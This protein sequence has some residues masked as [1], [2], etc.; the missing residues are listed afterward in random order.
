MRSI[1][2][3]YIEE[4]NLIHLGAS[5]D[6]EADVVRLQRL[7]IKVTNMAEP[8]KKEPYGPPAKKEE[9]KAQ[10]DLFFTPFFAL[11]KDINALFEHSIDNFT[12]MPTIWGP[13]L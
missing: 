1:A 2:Y 13:G 5:L 12:H 10:S 8:E 6:M 11:Q 3:I 4:R 9:N 7:M